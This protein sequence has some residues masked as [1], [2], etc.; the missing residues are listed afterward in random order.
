MNVSSRWKVL[1]S[2]K[3][4][5]KVS[6]AS[7]YASDNIS[8]N[9]QKSRRCYRLEAQ[10][11]SSTCVCVCVHVSVPAGFHSACGCCSGAPWPCSPSGRRWSRDCRNTLMWEPQTLD[12]WRK[13]MRTPHN[14]IFISKNK[15]QVQTWMHVSDVCLTQRIVGFKRRQDEVC[16]S[17]R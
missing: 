17:T 4:L 3:V 8:V 16:R 9:K 11:V 7:V 1:I 2:P 14:I 12:L 13:T 10:C 6:E 5:L 15:I